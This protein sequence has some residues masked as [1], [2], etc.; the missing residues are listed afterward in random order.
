MTY[1]LPIP[2]ME[3]RNLVTGSPYMCNVIF[4]ND[5]WSPILYMECGK[6]VM[7]SAHIYDMLFSGQLYKRSTV[8][9]NDKAG[10]IQSVIDH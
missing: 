6:L 5:I 7:G 10:S 4:V 9:P 3:C 2:Y 8:C 1:G